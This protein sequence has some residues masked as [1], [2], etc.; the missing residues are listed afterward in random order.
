M[1]KNSLENRKDDWL[2]QEYR[3]ENL[4][5]NIDL[6]DAKKL[7]D[8]HYREHKG[9]NEC[10]IDIIHFTAI[11]GVGFVILALFVLLFYEMAEYLF[12]CLK[13]F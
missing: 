4:C 11:I 13:G 12:Y 5:N 7:K 8:E 10:D 3:R 1:N 2:A 6:D 9:K